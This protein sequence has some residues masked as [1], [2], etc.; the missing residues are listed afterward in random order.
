[1]IQK[2]T[3]NQV[4]LKAPPDFCW[5]CWEDEP[6]WTQGFNRVYSLL[7]G[8]FSSETVAFRLREKNFW[9]FDNY[10]GLSASSLASADVSQTC[11]PMISTESMLCRVDWRSRFQMFQQIT[12]LDVFFCLK[13]LMCFCTW[14]LRMVIFQV[15]R[16]HRRCHALGNSNGNWQDWT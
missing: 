1:M 11:V 6:T 5:N 15:C 10:L 4:D 13:K 16:Q 3:L 9:L 2:V 12:N 14:K 8:C 7:G